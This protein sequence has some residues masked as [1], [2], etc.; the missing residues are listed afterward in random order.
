MLNPYPCVYGSRNISSRFSKYS[1]AY[2]SEYLE[3]LEEI[4]VENLEKYFP[5]DWK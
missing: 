3:N 5:G 1:E 2:A 4:Y